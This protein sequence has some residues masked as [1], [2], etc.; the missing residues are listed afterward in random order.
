LLGRHDRPDVS[1]L[2]IQD[3]AAGLEK[4]PVTV[5]Y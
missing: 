1:V 5:G 3:A 4:V 2:G